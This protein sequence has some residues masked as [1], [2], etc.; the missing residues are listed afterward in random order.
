MMSKNL[1]IFLALFSLTTTS[2]NKMLFFV[3]GAEQPK[4]KTDEEV[5][6]YAQ[7]VFD[8][9]GNIIR[10]K[11]FNEDS[12]S[13]PFGIK[14]MPTLML[15]ENNCLNK[16]ITTCSADYSK[17]ID[18]YNT[19]FRYTKVDT[20]MVLNG[21]DEILYSISGEEFS[22]DEPTF[23]IF[24]ARFVGR[25]NKRDVLPWMDEI[26]AET[27]FPILLVNLDYSEENTKH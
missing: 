18:D 21:I 3:I 15:A 16:F 1:L 4:Y 25:L 12:S 9:D 26:K 5:K 22:L 17:I 6:L 23:V 20:T 8:Y 2:C 14:S 19:N 27:D 24:Y 11:S 10:V 13:V 7:K